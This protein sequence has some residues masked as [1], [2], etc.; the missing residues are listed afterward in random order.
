MTLSIAYVLL[1]ASL[2]ATAMAQVAFKY[3]HLSG[4][5]R[6]LVIAI[7]LFVCVPPMNFLVVRELGV[8]R[9]YVF[10]SLS[11]AL[12][13]ILGQR[14]FAETISRRQFQGLALITL[15]CFLYTV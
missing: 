12:V 7:G 14:L 4:R 8:G 9:L 2:L 10:T 13:A 5:L 11:Y 6:S 3:Y 1:F 15:G